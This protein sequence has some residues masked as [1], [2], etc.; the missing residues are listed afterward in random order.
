M[1]GPRR[2]DAAAIGRSEAFAARRCPI[3][4]PACAPGDHIGPWEED[5]GFS[6]AGVGEGSREDVLAAALSAVW[7]RT[8]KCGACGSSILPE[9]VRRV[10]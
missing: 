5:A 4:L 6:A 10:L 8:G 3:P 7:T 1:T 2:V 9:S